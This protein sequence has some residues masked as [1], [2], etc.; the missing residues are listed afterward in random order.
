MTRSSTASAPRATVLATSR[1]PLRVAGEQLAPLGPLDPAGDAVELFLDRARAVNP[2]FTLDDAERADASALCARLDGMPLAIELASARARSMTIGELHARLDDRFRLLRASRR[3]Q[4]DGRHATMLATV[5]WSYQLLNADEQA[6]FDRLSVLAGSFDA[7]AAA[8]VSADALDEADALDALDGLV[9]RSMVIAEQ[10]A[11]IGTRFTLL[12]TLRQFAH[13]R[14]IGAGRCEAT[15]AAHLAH[16]LAVARRGSDLY[17]GADSGAGAGL[18]AAEW[19]NLRAAFL[20]AVTHGRRD[21]AAAL[22]RALYDFAVF[23]NSHEYYRWAAQA[24]ELGEPWPDRARRVGHRRVH[25]RPF[26]GRLQARR[27]GARGGPRSGRPRH[28]AGLVRVRRRLVPRRPRR[29]GRLASRQ[30]AGRGERRRAAPADSGRELGG[31]CGRGR[32]P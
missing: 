18:V 31:L 2:A 1:E 4:A 25:G 6:L 17:R 15:Q 26:R 29:R 11:G 20:F 13:D 28:V 7:A 21:E 9:D 22:L 32:P 19:D 14:L 10:A 8:A 16:F 5:E 12:E 3:D 30:R 27:R 23:T 24:A